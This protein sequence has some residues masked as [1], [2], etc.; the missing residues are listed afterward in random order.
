MYI[1]QC[2][3]E[4]YLRANYFAVTRGCCIVFN[5]VLCV[6]GGGGR[7]R[8]YLSGVS[9]HL[10][11][12]QGGVIFERRK[13]YNFVSNCYWTPIPKFHFEMLLINFDFLKAKYEEKLQKVF[14]FDQVKNSFAHFGG[15]KL[16]LNK[17]QK[18]W[19]FIFFFW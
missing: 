11:R 3:Q 15:L 13:K 16:K 10:T 18:T 17:I 8:F 2:T 1:V 6:C 14:S 7:Q 19:N 5:R 12:Q 9:A 4:A